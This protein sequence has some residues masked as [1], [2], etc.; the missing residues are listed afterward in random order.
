MYAGM[1][2]EKAVGIAAKFDIN[3]GGKIQVVRKGVNNG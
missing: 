3:T 1:T 2:P